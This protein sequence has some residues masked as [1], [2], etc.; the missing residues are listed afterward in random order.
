MFEKIGENEFYRTAQGEC[1]PRYATQESIA[2]ARELNADG[3]AAVMRGA[4]RLKGWQNGLFRFTVNQST[5]IYR[6]N[7]QGHYELQLG[8]T[9]PAN[10]GNG[11]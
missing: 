3:N 8:M 1:L 6:D 10:K 4:F 11:F 2:Q 7:G 5:A 9:P